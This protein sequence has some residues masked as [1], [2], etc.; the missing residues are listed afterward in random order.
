M[1]EKK[2]IYPGYFRSKINAAVTCDRAARKY[3]GEFADQNFPQ[4]PMGV[5]AE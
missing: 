2:R 3:H 1:L 5:R 4:S